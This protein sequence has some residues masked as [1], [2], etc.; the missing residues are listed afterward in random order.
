MST[1]VLLP[2]RFLSSVHFGDASGGGGLDALQLTCRADTF[3]NALCS[4]AAR[5]G[6]AVLSR[7]V[8]KAESG[9]IAFSDLLPWYKS[10]NAYEWYIPKPMLLISGKERQGQSLQEVRES[11]SIQ[12]KAKKRAF[13]RTSELRLHI[14]A[15]RRGSSPLKDEP[16]FAG[17][18]SQ[19]HFNGRERV[20]YSTGSYFFAPNAGLYIVIRL[21]QKEDMRWLS[22]LI[23]LTG[24]SGIGGRK[25]SGMG[26]FTEEMPYQVLNGRE[27]N[28]DTAVMYE[29]LMD[30]KATA[31]MSL[32]SLL[33]K[34]EE[35]ETA[36]HG[37]G[38]W[39]R[40]SGLSWSEGMESP[41]KMHTIYMMAAGSCLSHRLEG[42][43][44]DVSTPA[45]SHPVY[46][47]GKGLYVGVPT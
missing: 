44:A 4:E 18:I 41:A 14:D 11:A 6:E 27:N 10:G 22:T 34:K 45:V 8:A 42:R 5:L 35:I 1:Y 26:R 31:Q 37:T 29:L 19:V 9:E 43:I 23:H 7:L 15:C 25:S 20:P 32:C 17:S 3:F 46:R 40:R 13:L 33:P 28:K 47:Y 16:D 2:L 36:A 39:I 12:K 30:T 21:S 38:L 24:L